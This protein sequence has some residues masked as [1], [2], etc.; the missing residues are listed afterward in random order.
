VK[1]NLAPPDGI[2]PLRANYRRG[3]YASTE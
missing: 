1:V 3:Y 2:P